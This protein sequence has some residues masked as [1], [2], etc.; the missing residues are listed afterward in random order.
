[1]ELFERGDKMK[2]FKKLNENP[3]NVLALRA[4]I[5]EN[6]YTYGT[7]CNRIGFAS[8]RWYSRVRKE[9]S[10]T[11]SE[12]IRIREALGLSDNDVAHI[13]FGR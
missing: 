2:E 10:F 8:T 4:R 13:F 1:M 7:F 9:T 5:I 12:I 6:G 11:V 3:L